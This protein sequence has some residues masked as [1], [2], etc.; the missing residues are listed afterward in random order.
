MWL[1]LDFLLGFSTQHIS[2]SSLLGS[3]WANSYYPF[4]HSFLQLILFQP[5]VVRT[6]W[7]R[8]PSLS[9]YHFPPKPEIASLLVFLSIPSFWHHVLNKCLN[10]SDYGRGSS[11]VAWAICT[12]PFSMIFITSVDICKSHVIK[13]QVQ[14][15]ILD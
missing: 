10:V 5:K 3:K 9:P 2:Q 8:F 1:L 4:I 15:L 13:S 7:L 14:I 6:V 12:L 11:I